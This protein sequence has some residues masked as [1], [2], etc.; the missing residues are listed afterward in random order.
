M[1]NSDQQQILE[2]K[3]CDFLFPRYDCWTP[4][5]WANS[6]TRILTTYT[7]YTSITGILTTY[8][9]YTSITRILTTYTFYT[10]ITRILTTYTFY[11]SPIG[12]ENYIVFYMSCFLSIPREIFLFGKHSVLYIWHIHSEVNSIAQ[13]QHHI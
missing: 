13:D 10:S 4:N 7:F 5:K 2:N 11:T 1:V 9:F 8:T 6:I 3:K 12:S